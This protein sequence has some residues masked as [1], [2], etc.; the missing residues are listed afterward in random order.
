M[1]VQSKAVV[2]WRREQITITARM[3]RREEQYG[4]GRAGQ[5]GLD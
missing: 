5:R 4:V 2:G 3:E 1:V